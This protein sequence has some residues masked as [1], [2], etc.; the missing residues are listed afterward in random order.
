MADRTSIHKVYPQIERELHKKK[1]YAYGTFINK[2]RLY[3]V[4]SWMDC[5]ERG[6]GLYLPQK[7]NKKISC[8]FV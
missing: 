7:K 2:E 5:A 3:Y 1:D 8:V 6:L 4:L